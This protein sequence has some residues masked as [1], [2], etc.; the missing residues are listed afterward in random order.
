MELAEPSWDTECSRFLEEQK[1]RR[2]YEFAYLHPT[3]SYVVHQFPDERLNASC[4][5]ENLGR[6]YRRFVEQLDS[7]S[8]DCIEQF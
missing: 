2:S 3:G 1:C 5:G 6:S 8:V 4:F 7:N